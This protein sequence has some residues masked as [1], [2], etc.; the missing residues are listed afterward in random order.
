MGEA[1]RQDDRRPVKRITIPYTPRALQADLHKE[2]ESHRFSVIV[3]HRRFGKTY[4]LL[5]HLVKAAMSTTKEHGRF[6]Y[7]APFLKQAKTLAWDYLKRFCEPIPGRIFSESELKVTLPN[8]SQIRLFGADNYEALRGIYADGVVLDEYATS[9]PKVYTSILRP[10]LS[11]RKGWCC[12][13]STPNGRNHFFDMLQHAKATPDWFW[14]VLKASE[15]GLVDE[16]EL[17]DAKRTM[18]EEEYDREYECS[19]DSV[20]GKKIYPE[21]NMH[22]HLALE[23]L[24]PR[25][26]TVVYRG[27]DNTGLHPAVVLS[28]LTSTGQWQIFQEFWFDDVGAAESAEVIITWCNIHL[29]NGCTF[30]D[31]A[32]PAGKNRDG[33]KMSNKDYIAMKSQE[34][35]S[36]IFL[37]DGIQSWKPRRESVA[38]KLRT[39]RNGQPAILIDPSCKLVIEGFSGGY[40]YRELANMPGHFVEEAIKNK[41]ADIHDAIQYKATRMFTTGNALGSSDKFGDHYGEEDDFDVYDEASSGQ[42]TIT[43]Y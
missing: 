29:P 25:H 17:R 4:M 15:T 3:I 40:A 11:D 13:S 36:Y 21:F 2:L 23:D 18:T 27:W 19:F 28:H 43:G 7:L 34:M 42:N 35:G 33:N 1:Q 16:E 37:Q 8:G 20:I 12:F 24:T 31:Y 30:E 38:H 6:V 32:D 39:L 14:T 41:Y 26:P 22:L 9:D 10:A 5:N